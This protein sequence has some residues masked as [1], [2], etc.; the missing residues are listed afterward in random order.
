MNGIKFDL[1]IS[2]NFRGGQYFTT[3]SAS[4]VEGLKDSLKHYWYRTGFSSATGEI[5]LF[6]KIKVNDRIDKLPCGYFVYDSDGELQPEPGE[7]HEDEVNEYWRSLGANEGD[8]FE[9]KLELLL[10]PNNPHRLLGTWLTRVTDDYLDSR[11]EGENFDGTSI[12]ANILDFAN[13][14][15]VAPQMLAWLQS[16]KGIKFLESR[17]EYDPASG[18]L[19]DELARLTK[20]S[21]LTSDAMITKYI[22]ENYRELGGKPKLN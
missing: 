5:S 13:D 3:F 9:E 16:P 6:A 1:H 12:L 14:H 22:K 10:N 18:Y 2:P 21:A 11:I 4:A 20:G 15:K 17:D 8:N 7:S 19:S